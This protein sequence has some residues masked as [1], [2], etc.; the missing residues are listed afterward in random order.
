MSNSTALAFRNLMNNF[1]AAAHVLSFMTTKEALMGLVAVSREFKGQI[2]TALHM[3]KFHYVPHA[4]I[5]A[6]T[7]CP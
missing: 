4:Q 7:R 1:D 3:V 5:P 6:L 2:D